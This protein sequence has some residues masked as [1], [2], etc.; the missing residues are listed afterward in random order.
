MRHILLP[1]AVVIFIGIALNEPL[2]HCVGVWHFMRARRPIMNM[3]LALLS[4]RIL[5]VFFLKKTFFFFFMATPAAYGRSQARGWIGAA[6][7]GLHHS[8]SNVGSQPCLQPTPQLMATLDPSPASEARVWIRIL[9]NPSWVH[10]CW[11]MTGTPRIL[12][13]LM[14]TFYYF[15]CRDFRYHLLDSFL[16]T[17]HYQSIDEV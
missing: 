12:N 8:P 13:V 1:K 6:A 15:L 7:A 2:E 9:M 17:F 5:N 11:A 10:S 14:K 3:V 16:G 4:F